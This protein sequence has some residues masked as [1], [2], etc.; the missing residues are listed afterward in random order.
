MRLERWLYTVPMRLRSI[1]RRQRAEQ[2]L[3]EELRYHVERHAEMEVARGMPV[4]QAR[5][6][7]LHA[8]G[9]VEQQKEACRDMRRLRVVE[10]LAR[11]LRQTVRALRR[12]SAFTVTA[13]LITG[14]GIGATTAVFSVVNG[15]L[16]KPLP[17]A[18]ADTLVA[19]RHTA[20]GSAGGVN[21]SPTMFF[22]YR[23]ENRTFQAFG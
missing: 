23:D 8:M 11:D 4:E 18:D 16:I 10:D 9:G 17:Y 1:V 6:A 19:I 7:A 3:D 14:I 12:N 5:R 22:T 21:T 2:D 15:V 13:L 20:F